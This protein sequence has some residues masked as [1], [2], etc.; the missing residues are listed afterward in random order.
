MQDRTYRRLSLEE[1]RRLYVMYFSG[2]KLQEISAELG[3]DPRGVRSALNRYPLPWYLRR[4]ASPLDWAR[5][6]YDRAQ[7]ARSRARRRERLKCKFIRDYVEEKLALGWT[8]ELIAGRLR[9]EHP[10]YKISYEAIYEWIFKERRDLKKYLLRA[11]K[12]KRGKPGAREYPKR[13][14]AAPKRSIEQRDAAANERSAVGHLESDQMVGSGSACVLNLAERSSR[15]IRL[16]KVDN[17]QSK[18]VNRVLNGL[19][20]ATP[21]GAKN[22]LTQDN[23][24]EHAR[25]DELERDTKILV[26]FCH[27][28]CASERGTV[29]NRNGIV[30][31]YFP[32]GTN[33]DNVSEV[34]L[35]AV[36][37]KINST[38]MKLL[39]FRT[40]EEVYQEQLRQLLETKK[41]A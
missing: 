8:P 19:L 2:K 10:G 4:R 40:P 37:N 14:P 29:E 41:A 39:G 31:R 16:R 1:W 35:L 9:L 38:P 11:G 15:F 26:Y 5:Y 21:K 34:E 18:T 33:F 27:P 17:L 28:Y 6:A 24:S 30:R 3:R 36:Q 7:D 20:T 12:P 23:G 25:H 13:Q 22:T 32:K